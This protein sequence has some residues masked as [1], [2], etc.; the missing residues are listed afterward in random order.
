MQSYLVSSKGRSDANFN[1]SATNNLVNY[2]SG[3]W[4]NVQEYYEEEHIIYMPAGDAGPTYT[5][6]YD[7]FRNTVASAA[8][9]ESI[10]GLFTTALTGQEYQTIAFFFISGSGKLWFDDYIYDAHHAFTYYTAIK[11]GLFT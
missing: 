11:Y 5:T 6:L 1:L 3:K 7:F 10:D 9:G 4:G 8:M 2:V